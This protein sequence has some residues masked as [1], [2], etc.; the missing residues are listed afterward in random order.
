MWRYQHGCWFTLAR[1]GQGDKCL[2]WNF[3]GII[4]YYAW[5]EI[6]SIRMRFITCKLSICIEYEDAQNKPQNYHWMKWVMN[7]MD[8][9]LQYSMDE[10]RLQNHIDH[11]L[12]RLWN[13]WHYII[14][15]DRWI[16]VHKIYHKDE[17]KFKHKNHN[18]Y[19][20]VNMDV[21]ILCHNMDE[22]IHLKIIICIYL[23]GL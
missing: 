15:P 4:L 14:V 3:D 7:L 16:H 13:W 22:N 2:G 12:T 20:V 17:I 9:H 6:I 5:N 8:E 23:W 11:K 1:W 18:I 19:E 10:I 21:E